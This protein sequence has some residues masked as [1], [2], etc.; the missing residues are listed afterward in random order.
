MSNAVVSSPR[1]QEVPHAPVPSRPRVESP[2]PSRDAGSCAPAG[3]GIPARR[4]DFLGI[5]RRNS[6]DCCN[7]RGRPPL[8]GAIDRR[9]ARSDGR[10]LGA[11]G[12]HA[13]AATRCGGCR[14]WRFDLRDWRHRQVGRERSGDARH[15]GCRGVRPDPRRLAQAHP[16]AGGSPW[17]RAP[18]K[19]HPCCCQRG[20]VR[21]RSDQRRMDPAR[22]HAHRAHGLRGGYGRTEGARHRGNGA[23]YIATMG[24]AQ[25]RHRRRVP[26]RRRIHGGPEPQ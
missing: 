4:H 21:V 23:G 11:K 18:R 2:R 17:G 8:A 20:V 13:N 26:T 10:S 19:E 12:G 14:M 15:Q 3:R 22:R 7:R 24:V 25:Q 9:T 6:R 1:S 5:R 16:C